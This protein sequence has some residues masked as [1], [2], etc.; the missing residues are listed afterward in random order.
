MISNKII[1]QAKELNPIDDI[2]FKK[3]GEED[4]RVERSM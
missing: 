1:A 4:G 2:F 3:M